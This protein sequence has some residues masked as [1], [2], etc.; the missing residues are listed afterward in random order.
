[1]N[2]FPTHRETEGVSRTMTAL[3]PSNAWKPTP[4]IP[5]DIGYQRLHSWSLNSGDRQVRQSC[6]MRKV[7]VL[8]T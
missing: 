1:M 2:G 6:P 8:S 3:E 5:I 4:N 7:A